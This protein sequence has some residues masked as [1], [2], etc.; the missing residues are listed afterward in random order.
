MNFYRPFRRTVCTVRVLFQILELNKLERE[1]KDVFTP[2]HPWLMPS[3]YWLQREQPSRKR[4][5][6]RETG[7]FRQV[8]LLIRWCQSGLIWPS[9][10][11][12][13]T[14]LSALLMTTNKRR[15]RKSQILT[16]LTPLLSPPSKLSPRRVLQRSTTNILAIPTQKS[17]KKKRMKKKYIFFTDATVFHFWCWNPGEIHAYSNKTSGVPGRGLVLTIWLQL[18]GRPFR[19][20]FLLQI[21]EKHRKQSWAKLSVLLYYLRRSR[22]VV[23]H[24]VLLLLETKFVIHLKQSCQVTEVQQHTYAHFPEIALWWQ[25][26]SIIVSLQVIERQSLILFSFLKITLHS[27]PHVWL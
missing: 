11:M 7:L 12:S 13:V 23:G 3:V 14:V 5:S 9:R 26:L 18:A 10:A 15:R 8:P 19:P 6:S 16:T 17:F 1:A 4:L 21:V 24:N 20:L 25:L 2:T 27:D 22:Q